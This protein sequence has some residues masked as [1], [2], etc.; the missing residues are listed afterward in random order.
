LI[1][2]LENVGVTRFKKLRSTPLQ[3]LLTAG[4]LTGLLAG[5]VYI[6]AIFNFRDINL[7]ASMVFVLGCLVGMIVGWRSFGVGFVVGSFVGVVFSFGWAF[8]DHDVIDL[9]QLRTLVGIGPSDQEWIQKA[10]RKG[11]YLPREATHVRFDDQSGWHGAFR[12]D[13]ELE[14]DAVSRLRDQKKLKK[15]IP[16][17][18]FHCQ[19]DYGFL[20]ATDSDT[21]RYDITSF[22]VGNWQGSSSGIM[23]EVSKVGSARGC[24]YATGTN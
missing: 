5:Y 1:S 20:G 23:L 19:P 21:K 3:I 12:Y 14:S 4:I 9:D 7:I 11:I 16:V 15:Q 8:K 2:I 10:D 18:R 22:R 24:A 6:V 13:F 17:D